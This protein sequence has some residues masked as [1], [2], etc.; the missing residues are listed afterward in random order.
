MSPLLSLIKVIFY[1]IFD[2]IPAA[3]PLTIHLLYARLCAMLL[4]KTD[5]A[6]TFRLVRCGIPYNPAV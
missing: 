1:T 6:V 3:K 4:H 5:K 2:Y